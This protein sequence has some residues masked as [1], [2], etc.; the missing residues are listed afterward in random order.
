MENGKILMN[1][2][3]EIN[4]KGHFENDDYVFFWGGPFSNWH[5][6]KVPMF[7]NSHG[8]MEFNCVEQAFMYFKAIEF[9]DPVT[10]A[11]IYA[12]KN[13]KA[14]KQLGR[15]IIGFKQE[16]WDLVKQQ[17]MFKC[18]LQKFIYNDDLR[19]ILFVTRDKMICESSPKDLVWGNGLHISDPNILDKSKWPGQN[20]LGK[21]LIRVREYLR[22]T[23]Y[24][25]DYEA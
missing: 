4:V 25:I 14:Q 15:Q 7:V 23:I 20:L 13:A 11:K 16:R 19:R 9:S 1:N 18:C 5:K 22:D 24:L 6:C 3:K 10:A 12:E 8:I 21:C 17:I 2:L